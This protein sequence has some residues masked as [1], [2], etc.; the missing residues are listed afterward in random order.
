MTKRIDNP[1]F[2]KMPS[3]YFEHDQWS[4]KSDEDIQAK[5]SEDIR[6]SGKVKGVKLG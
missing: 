2:D 1:H 5:W 6:R 3:D 4:D